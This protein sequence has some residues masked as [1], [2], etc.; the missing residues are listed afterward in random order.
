V[1]IFCVTTQ[2][3]S[4]KI[5]ASK[6]ILAFKLAAMCAAVAPAIS[7]SNF[8]RAEVAAAAA[9]QK[10]DEIVIIGNPPDARDVVSPVSTLS[11]TELLLK[12]AIRSAKH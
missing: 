10:V 12:K 7:V 8:A 4:R 2:F 6:R 1:F 11:G 9:P 3:V 5:I